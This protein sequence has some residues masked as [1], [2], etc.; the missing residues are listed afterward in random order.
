[1]PIENYLRSLLFCPANK[2]KMFYK[3]LESESDLIIFDLEDAVASHEKS[4]ARIILKDWFRKQE[5]ETI[6][7]IVLRIN[8]IEAKD[9]KRDVEMLLSLKNYPKIVLLPKVE[10]EVQMLNVIEIFR[11]REVLFIPIIESARGV[12]N[13]DSILNQR[14]SMIFL[15]IGNADLSADIGCENNRTALLYA[16]SKVLLH[17]AIHKIPVIDSPYFNINDKESFLSDTEFGKSIGFDARAAVHPKQIALINDT[18][19]PTEEQITRAQNI[20]AIATKGV[21]SID[22]KMIDEAMAKKARRIIKKSKYFKV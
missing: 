9:F 3:A 14:N 5:K 20:I 10:S 11:N 16:N 7:R 1:M 22:G 4:D 12:K 13:I 18:Y 15:M 17:C 19:T 8:P 2:E 6:S 21:G